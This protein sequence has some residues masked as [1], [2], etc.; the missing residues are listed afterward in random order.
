M[1]KKKCLAVIMI[2]LLLGLSYVTFAGAVQ[3][4][5]G[6]CFTYSNSTFCAPVCQ[7][8]NKTTCSEY[9]TDALNNY[10]SDIVEKCTAFDNI[11]DTLDEFDDKIQIYVNQ[12]F[13][14]LSVGFLDDCNKAKIDAREWEKDYVECNDELVK[15]SDSKNM[16]EALERNITQANALK[17]QYYNRNNELQREN[18]NLLSTQYT[19]GFLVFG[20][21]ALFMYIAF[22]RKKRVRATGDEEGFE[23]H[24]GM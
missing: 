23:S 19:V 5:E 6:E 8:V 3:L 22:I 9:I 10:T 21:T 20:G 11:S 2:A 15:Y 17:S 16:I 4:G 14:R 13:G 18:E 12:T 1:K 7:K 24:E